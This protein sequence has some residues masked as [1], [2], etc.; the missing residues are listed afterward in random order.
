MVLRMTDDLKQ[1]QDRN[2]SRAASPGNI[3]ISNSTQQS[4]PVQ[5]PYIVQQSPCILPP[6]PCEF[7]H[8]SKAIY[9]TLGICLGAY[10]AH[11]FYAGYTGKAVVQL[12]FGL[13]CFLGLVSFIWAIIEVCV[14]DR[15]AT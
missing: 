13:S 14:V 9:L 4:A 3:V 8:K 12:L 11:N 7:G 6:K 15:D 5:P 10:G 1:R 2:E